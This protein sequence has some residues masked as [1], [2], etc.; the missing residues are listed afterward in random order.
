[1][2]TANYQVLDE[3]LKVNALLRMYNPGRPVYQYD[4]EWGMHSPAERRAGRFRAAQR[5]HLWHDAPRRPADPLS[6]GGMLHGAS[7]WEMFA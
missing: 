6:P 4:T 2:L 7:S 5:Q 3:I 1:M